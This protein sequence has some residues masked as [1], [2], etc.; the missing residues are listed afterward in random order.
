MKSPDAEAREMT[1]AQLAITE[2][3]LRREVPRKQK[4]LEA[5]RRERKHRDRRRAKAG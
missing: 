5:V 3:V 1:D 4:L 2:A